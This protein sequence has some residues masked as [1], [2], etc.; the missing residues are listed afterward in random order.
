MGK[1]WWTHAILLGQH[2]LSHDAQNSDDFLSLGRKT[3]GETN[4][5]NVFPVTNIDGTNGLLVNIYVCYLI[6]NLSKH[7]F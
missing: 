1:K 6:L 5:H 3:Q 7:N 4:N 2:C